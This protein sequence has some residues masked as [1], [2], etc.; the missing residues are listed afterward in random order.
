MSKTKKIVLVSMIAIFLLLIGYF[1]MPKTSTHCGSSLHV[2]CQV[3]KCSMGIPYNPRPIGGN[4]TEC[5]M[6]K[7]LEC[8]TVDYSELK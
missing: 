3:C 2:S 6:G 5:F 7:L 1:F 4:S 8:K